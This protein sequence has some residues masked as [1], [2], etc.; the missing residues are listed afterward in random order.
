MEE[1]EEEIKIEEKEKFQIKNPI[2]R[3]IVE[4]IE[5]LVIA[6]VLALVIKTF[7]IETTEVSGDSMYSTLNHKD[8]LLVNR[9]IYKFKSPERGDIIVFL[10]D[11]ENRNYIKRIIATPGE[12]VDIHDGNVYINGVLLEEDYITQDTYNLLSDAKEFPYTLAEGEYFAMGDN[13]GNSLDSRSVDVGQLTLDK[14]RGRAVCRIYPFNKIC[15]FGHLD[16]ECLDEAEN[17]NVEAE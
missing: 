2:L 10:P 12:T 13:R 17:E 8:K 5:V 6:F 7:V 11:N 14:I 3:E 1:K 9:F 4:W 16:Y 15:G